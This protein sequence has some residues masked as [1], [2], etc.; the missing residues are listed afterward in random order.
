MPADL[1]SVIRVPY[2]SMKSPLPLL[3]TLFHHSSTLLATPLDLRPYK[4]ILGLDQMDLLD[5][6]IQTHQLIPIAKPDLVYLQAPCS[7]FTRVHLSPTEWLI[8]YFDGSPLTD[9]ESVVTWFRVQI[10]STFNE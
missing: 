2:E 7:Y 9:V 6:W 1:L 4:S 5:R 8:P 3:S 10:N